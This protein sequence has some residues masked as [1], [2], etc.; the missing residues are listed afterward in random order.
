MSAVSNL[1]SDEKNS[2]EELFAWELIFLCAVS[3]VVTSDCA[4]SQKWR[5]LQ[6]KLK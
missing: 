2:T 4:V 3:W 6:T 5:G 1:F